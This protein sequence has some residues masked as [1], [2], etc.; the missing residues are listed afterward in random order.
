MNR[1]IIITFTWY[2]SFQCWFCIIGIRN[3]LIRTCTIS[4]IIKKKT[5]TEIRKETINE[6]ISVSSNVVSFVVN[7]DVE[8]IAA[9]QILLSCMVCS[10][11]LIILRSIKDDASSWICSR[12]MNYSDFVITCEIYVVCL[13]EVVVLQRKLLLKFFEFLSNYENKL[14]NEN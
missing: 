12:K 3:N 2:C 9:V 10:G 14:R 13:P 8:P 5:I 1:F 7:D 6:R 4:Y 11:S